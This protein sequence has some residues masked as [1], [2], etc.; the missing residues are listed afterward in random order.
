MFDPNVHQ[1]IERV[2]SKDFPDGFIVDVFQDGYI[3]HGR[4][5]CGPRSS[6]LP[7][8][9]PDASETTSPEDQDY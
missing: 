5:L 4:E 2:E 9:P 1:A 6:A 7:F 3:F 8:T